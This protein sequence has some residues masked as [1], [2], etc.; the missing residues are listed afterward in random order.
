MPLRQVKAARAE[1]DALHASLIALRAEL[2]LPDAFPAEVER[3]AEDAVDAPLPDLDRTALPLITIDPEGAKDLDQALHIG[4][5]DDGFV[6]SYAI[7]D[8]ARVVRPGGALDRVARERG[9][10]LYAP[11]GSI[12]LHPRVLSEDAASLVPGAV[13]SAYLWTFHLDAR[14]T[15]TATSLERAR[16][17]STHQW[18]YADAQRAIDDPASGAAPETLELLAVVG[19]LRIALEAERGGASLEMPETDV[20]ADGDGYRL[21]RRTLLD[22]ERWNAQISLLTGMSAAALQVSAGRGVLRTMPPASDES[23]AAFRERTRA[24]GVPWPEGRRYGD[25]LRD[26]DRTR[27]ASLAILDEAAALFRGAGYLVLDGSVPA[28]HSQSAIGA[29]YAHATA[30]LRRL[31]DRYVLAH[32]LAIANGDEIPAWASEGLEGLP[33]IMRASGA[34]AGRL[35]R[36]A[37]DAIEA[38]VLHGR[39]GEEFE[40]VVIAKDERRADIHVQEPAIDARTATDAAPGTRITVR[41][42]RADIA[43]RTVEFTAV[44]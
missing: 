10:T 12:P 13:R 16:V 3:E 39:E 44:E 27:P 34:L 43:A 29:P 23:I 41:L 15:V 14:G 30:P 1:H 38:A 33:E 36:G 40:A 8:L 18:S 21:Q 22:V 19:P 24:L 35:E 11:D 9:Q 26:L 5:T 37:I 7:A 28:E 4:R 42:E 17:R 32:C 2:E 6:V 31:V 25:Y 20:V